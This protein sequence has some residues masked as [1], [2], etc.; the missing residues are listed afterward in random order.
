V[1]VLSVV[2]VR[3]ALVAG[4]IRVT[5]AFATAASA[6]STTTPSSEPDTV[7][8]YIPA[9]QSA[10]ANTM[11]VMFLKFIVTPYLFFKPHFDIDGEF[12]LFVNKVSWVTLSPSKR[13]VKDWSDKKN[14][15]LTGVFLVT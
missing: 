5:G 2:A 9:Q 3:V 6:G 1:P 8:P 7:C 12:D 4:L 11:R 15:G 10:N 13:D 14:L